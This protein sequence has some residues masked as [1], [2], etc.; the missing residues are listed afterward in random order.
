MGPVLTYFYRVRNRLSPVRSLM[1]GYKL[2]DVLFFS[3]IFLEVFEVDGPSRVFYSFSM[4]QILL[5]YYPKML[6][7][8]IFMERLSEICILRIDVLTM[9]S[10]LFDL[11]HATVQSF[12]L[13]VYL[14][15]SYSLELFFLPVWYAESPRSLHVPR[16]E[17]FW[18]FLKGLL[19]RI[20][21]LRVFEG[22]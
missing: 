4:S 5:L 3:P 10:F 18:F 20:W 13:E 16:I 19:P 12:L 8:Y 6:F 1:F 21:V 2:S 9:F 14:H 7:S 11:C 22:A 17:A 15:L